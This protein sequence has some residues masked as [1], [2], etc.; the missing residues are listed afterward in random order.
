VF[1]DGATWTFTEF[2]ALSQEQ[3]NEAFNEAPSR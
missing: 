3:L 2:I 1:R